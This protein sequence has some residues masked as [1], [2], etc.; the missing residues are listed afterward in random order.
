MHGVHTVADP[1]SHELFDDLPA[2]EQ[3]LVADSFRLERRE[4]FEQFGDDVE[5]SSLVLV[6]SG[7]VRVFLAG[8][9][10]RELTLALLDSGEAFGAAPIEGAR[11]RRIEALESSTVLSCTEDE[12][13]R[14]VEAAPT[15]G[16]RVLGLLLESA[17]S[18]GDELARL[19]FCAVPARLAAKLLE[20]MERYGR[21]T[22]AGHP[23]R[24]PLH[25]HA[26]LGHDR[27]EPRDADEGPRRAALERLDRRARPVDLGARRGG[28]RVGRRHQ[29]SRAARHRAI[30]ERVHAV[31]VSP[32]VVTD[33]ERLRRLW[34]ALHHQHRAVAPVALVEDDEASWRARSALYLQWLGEGNAF[35]FLAE[36]NGEPVGYAVCCLIDGPDDSF[37]VGERYGDLYSLSVAEA[38]AVRASAPGC[39]TPSIASSSSARST[40]CGSR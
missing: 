33:V 7:R 2:D 25:A 3:A 22:P 13:A 29:L 39:S 37:P 10:D 27:H 38:N 12:L 5:T 4:Q 34:L 24:R 23:H 8:P 35:G 31:T 21:V 19:A 32:M 28:A 30:L 14:L 11:P 1:L 9:D 15:F 40:T 18:V 16:I 36:R 6:V 20:L 26:A 17:R